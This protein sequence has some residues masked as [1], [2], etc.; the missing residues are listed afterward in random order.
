[1][2]V[3]PLYQ[4]LFSST[5]SCELCTELSEVPVLSGSARQTVPCQLLNPE[6]DPRFLEQGSL[7]QGVEVHL[8]LVLDRNRI[9][10]WSKNTLLLGLE[11]QQ[12]TRW[13]SRNNSRHIRKSCSRLDVIMTRNQLLV[14]LRNTIFKHRSLYT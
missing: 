12:N 1:M 14:A 3:G 2:T 10:I 4:R 8:F 11:T 9:Y 13:L 5:R 6:D 7:L